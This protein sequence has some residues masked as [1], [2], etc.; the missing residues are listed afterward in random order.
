VNGG[1]NGAAERLAYSAFAARF[2]LDV[3]DNQ[4]PQ[5]IATSGGAVRVDFSEME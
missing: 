4:N 5:V 3:V 1:G 2:L